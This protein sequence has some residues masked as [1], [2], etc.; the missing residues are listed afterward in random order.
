MSRFSP[1]LRFAT[2]CISFVVVIGIGGGVGWWQTERAVRSPTLRKRERPAATPVSTGPSSSQSPD[3]FLKA[4]AAE[5]PLSLSASFGYQSVLPRIGTLDPFRPSY[6]DVGPARWGKHTIGVTAGP[7]PGLWLRVRGAIETVQSSFRGPQW[8]SKATL[9]LD[10]VMT[11]AFIYTRMDPTAPFTI[12]YAPG[13]DGSKVMVSTAVGRNA[14]VPPGAAVRM[15]VNEL[16]ASNG[17]KLVQIRKD[18]VKIYPTADAGTL[19]QKDPEDTG[20]R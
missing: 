9:T 2:V 16:L 19:D 1:S 12:Y 15:S 14:A 18:V 13:I 5:P 6:L 20:Y 3:E 17:Y 8:P 7:A 4:S 10:H 11:I